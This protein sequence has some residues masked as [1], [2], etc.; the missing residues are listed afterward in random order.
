[1]HHALL[2]HLWHS[3]F[4]SLV[5]SHSIPFPEMLEK[6]FFHSFFH[7]SQISPSC[8]M[9]IL[10]ALFAPAAPP[11]RFTSGSHFSSLATGSAEG[12][13]GVFGFA[14]P[15]R[16]QGHHWTHKTTQS[17]VWSSFS[18][19]H[20]NTWLLSWGKAWN[21]IWSQ[22]PLS[23]CNQYFSFQATIY[24]CC[25]AA[26]LAPLLLLRNTATCR[27]YLYTRQVISA[28]IFSQ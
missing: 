25:L 9:P 13:T 2:C 11:A 14:Q 21:N 16:T 24:L 28:A 6:C 8:L 5:P 27:W 10:R 7:H 26:Q 3:S 17:W 18:C 15:Q 12:T 19:L 1:M 4:V 20:C 22:L 23:S